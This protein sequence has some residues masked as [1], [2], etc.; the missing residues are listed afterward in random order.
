MIDPVM[1][2]M[3]LSPD[4]ESVTVSLSQP[5]LNNDERDELKRKYC[6]KTI[7]LNALLIK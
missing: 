2:S 4:D 3:Q 1:M 6:A 5:L 7:N